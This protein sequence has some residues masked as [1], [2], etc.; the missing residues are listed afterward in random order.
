V[1]LLE[2]HCAGA[3]LADENRIVQKTFTATGSGASVGL[4]EVQLLE[5]HH[6]GGLP[7]VGVHV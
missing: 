6:A 1:Q 7:T 5:L 2:L 4:L 3:F